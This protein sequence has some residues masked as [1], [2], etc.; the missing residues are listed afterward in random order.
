MARRGT[1]ARSR[2]EEEDDAE[3]GFFPS[4]TAP[5]T[6][7]AARV[8]ALGGV[9][10]CVGMLASIGV[11]ASG[12]RKG[13]AQHLLTSGGSF[14]EHGTPD[15]TPPQGPPSAAAAGRSNG[16]PAATTE[17][18]ASVRTT[19]AAAAS[20][21]PAGMGS[22]AQRREA[23][24]AEAVTSAVP[25]QAAAATTLSDR[26]FFRTYNAYTRTAP[27]TW[28]RWEHIGEPH[29][30]S[31]F[32]AICGGGCACENASGGDGGAASDA[33]GALGVAA[34]DVAWSWEIEGRTYSGAAVEHTFLTPGRRAVSLA[35]TAGG[36]SGGRGGI[37]SDGSD[38]NSDSGGRDSGGAA[39]A[40][41]T[42][43]QAD[44]MV[45]YVRREIRALSDDDRERFVAALQTLYR[46]PTREGR[47]LYGTRYRGMESF[48]AQ[49]L[50]GAGRLECD[51]WHDDAGIVTHHVAFTLEL[52]QV[53]QLLDPS[54]AV[55]YWEY[56]LDATLYSRLADSPVFADD[57]LGQMAPTN[58]LK[59]PAKGRWAFTR[60]ATA[61]AAAAAAATTATGTAAAAA[62]AGAG[63]GARATAFGSRA[64]RYGG[65]G[66]YGGYGGGATGN[67]WGLL[68]SAWNTNPSPFLARHDEV[69]GAAG[70][71]APTC[72]I[73]AKCFRSATLAAMHNCLNGATHG[74]VHILVGG[75]WG[76]PDEQWLREWGLFGKVVLIA[77]ALWRRGYLRVPESCAGRSPEDCRT[78]CPSELYESRGMD[79]Y[80]VLLEAN[81]L[82]WTAK[83]SKGKIYFDAATG[84]YR[85]AGLESDAAATAAVWRR[86]LAALC[87]PGY[88]GEMFTSAA[89]YDPSFWIIHP[90]A[91]RLLGQRRLAAAATGGPCFDETWGYN[92]NG[93]TGD[94]GVVCDWAGAAAAAEASADAA[95]ATAAT[96]SAAAAAVAAATAKAAMAN[97]VAVKAV[98]NTAGGSGF[99]AVG[100]A[101]A[102]TA[103]AAAAA[104]RAAATAAAAS[105]GLVMP[106]C[107]KG[108]CTGHNA[109]DVLPFDLFL[110]PQGGAA[111][112]DSGAD[113]STD[114][115]APAMAMAAAGEA[116]AAAAAAAGIAAAGAGGGVKTAVGPALGLAAAADTEVVAPPGLVGPQRLTNAELYAAIHPHS[117]E[118]P[119]MYDSYTWPWC[120]EQGILLA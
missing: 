16:T 6:S 21:L 36:S 17:A 117:N 18:T 85:V 44:V 96:A 119:Y 66:N 74:P 62:A 91:E 28:S 24:D 111:L 89:P 75:E 73:Y 54:V 37:G 71:F 25:A 70:F 60:I 7:P 112:D 113:G 23:P 65:L 100:G 15:Q 32:E 99:E 101:Q 26:P 92:H 19:T 47:V 88:V 116:A 20:E 93:D 76:H 114:A 94:D 118:L 40:A 104:E 5:V 84:A 110:L 102:A 59:T 61:S 13:A 78:A 86:M 115:V 108:T 64:G 42:S 53:L 9:V 77:K 46:V 51:H 38:G 29:R 106:T 31:T 57:W 11:R 80:D 55:P 68:R 81:A 3:A 58:D 34:A 97:T 52:E 56:T 95:A 8:F 22:P 109:D 35:C 1:R 30:P 98:A 67:S 90:S 27:I 69:N 2:E 43:Y 39:A 12:F 48:A 79:A 103:V 50:D 14:A 33:D 87:D 4:S 105:P 49:H 120:E 41:K 63:A 107:V 83:S 45:K 10:L 82:L 72:A